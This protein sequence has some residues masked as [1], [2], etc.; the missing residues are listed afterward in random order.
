MSGFRAKVAV[1]P[2]KTIGNHEPGGHGGPTLATLIAVSVGALTFV[3]LLM[4][5]SASAVA[6]LEKTGSAFF[7]FWRQ[8]IMAGFGF[9]AMVY[10]ARHDYHRLQKW[11]GPL[12]LVSVGLLILVLIPGIGASAGGASR[13]IGWGSVG[14]QPSELAK[15]ATLVFCAFALT[16]PGHDP[17]T[18]KE[19]LLPTLPV[20]GAFA[21]LVMLQPDMGTTL[22]MGIGLFVVLWAAGLPKRAWFGLLVLAAAGAFVL[23]MTEDYR[24]RRMLA[25]IDPW[26]D[27]GDAGY[28]SVQ[29]LLAI[30]SGGWTGLG[31]GAGRQKWTFL[32]NAHTDFVFA[33]IGEELG[34]VGCVAVMALFVFF[35]Y[36]G[37]RVAANAPDRFGRLLAAGITGWVCI[38]A[39]LNI[40]VTTGRLPVTGI[41]LPLVSAGGSA[42]VV[43]LAAMG[44]LI[45]IARS[46]ERPSK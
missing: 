35:G 19:F 15:L 9:I 13:W 12:V 20:V 31:L 27:A 30:G 43:S 33:V 2:G 40:G 8:L 36:V 3:G 29:S 42:L 7:I 17:E 6:A 39:L 45:S 23:S 11:A 5:M 46:S 32:P 14:F 34:F 16:R 18:P 38:Q 4:V 10:L 26:A 25:F 28:H 41:P 1:G 21:V 22:S 44:I 37:F 24:R